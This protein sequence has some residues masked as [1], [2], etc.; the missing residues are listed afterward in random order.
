M[1]VLPVGP[2][3]G[4]FA[5]AGHFELSIFFKQDNVFG[6]RARGINTLIGG[7]RTSAKSRNRHRSPYSITSVASSDG[8]TSSVRDYC[9][10]PKRFSV[11]LLS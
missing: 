4:L 7:S 10:A 6:E 3:I 9:D 5:E 1:N 11:S 8:G 2:G